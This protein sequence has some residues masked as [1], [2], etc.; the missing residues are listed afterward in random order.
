MKHNIKLLIILTLTF[1]GVFAFA[2]DVAAENT[3]ASF[4]TNLFSYLKSLFD[5]TV[6]VSTMAKISG[7]IVLLISTMKVSFLKP[8]WEKLGDKKDWLAPA[9]GLVAGIVGM[10]VNGSVDFN[11]VLAALASGALAPYVHDLLDQVKKIPGLG[12]IWL[13][14]IDFIKVILK[15][16]KV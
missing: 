10:F 15:A 13:T 2:Q 14:I 11:I 9:L 3:D 4:F 16:P 7:G 5:D 6:K 1:V 8:L 12:Q